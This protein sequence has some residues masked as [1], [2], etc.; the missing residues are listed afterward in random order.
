MPNFEELTPEQEWWLAQAR[1][2]V[3]TL[4]MREATVSWLAQT[5]NA[6]FSV[7]TDSALYVLMLQEREDQA[8]LRMIAQGMLMKALVQHGM[9]LPLPMDFV[10]TETVQG[11][12]TRH[13]EGE[14]RTPNTLT[15][16]EAEA[17][18]VYLAH[19]HTA[20]VNLGAA[21]A[22]RPVLDY[23]GLFGAGGIYDPGETNMGIFTGAQLL[24]MKEVAERV[25][26][27]MQSLG[28]SR[29][30][31]GLIHADLLLHNI[32]FHEGQVRALDWEYSGWGYYLYDL[33]PLLWQMKPQ[34][35]YAE[36]EAALWQ[37]YTR[38]RPLASEHQDLLETFIAGRQVASMRWVAAN[39]HNPAYAGKVERILARRTTE[40]AGFLKSGVLQRWP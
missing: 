24:T 35:N 34:P 36:I 18:G 16:T 7:Q 14:T 32:L 20:D 31:V 26:D 13:L 33:T 38:I 4:N 25:R 17:V 8:L 23:D 1:V 9:A 39:Q 21:A 10:L 28:K 12:L 22:V 40:L 19:L 6:V 27:A 30:E 15:P 37:G 11:M 3:A 2:A 29:A 5:H